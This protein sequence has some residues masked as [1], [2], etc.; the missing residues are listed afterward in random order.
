[1]KFN[2]EIQHKSLSG[3][4]VD[5][6]KEEIFM[7][8][9]TGGDRIPETKIANELNI[10]RAPVR[11]AFKELEN[12]GFVEIISRKGTFVVDFREDEVQELYEI[13]VILEEKIFKKL[14]KNKIL[15]EN[16]FEYLEELIEEMVEIAKSDK[17]ENRKVFEVNKLDMKFHRYLWCKS[18]SKWTIKILTTLYNQLQ[19]AMIL[20]AK[21]EEN[22]VK[23]SLKHQK[24]IDNLRNNDLKETKNAVIEHIK[25]LSKQVED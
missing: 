14:I 3:K 2:K 9:Y 7:E 20:D 4:V 25:T 15:S 5:Y 8:N 18:E 10:S 11:E 17:N 12:M 16:D 24:I 19:L 13:R 23:A 21:K 22:L 1:M 6:L